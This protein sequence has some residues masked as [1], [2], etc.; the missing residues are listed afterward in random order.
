MDLEAGRKLAAGALVSCL[1]TNARDKRMVT[2][3]SR[4]DA[5]AGAVTKEW[6]GLTIGANL[7]RSIF[8]LSET[9]EVHKTVVSPNFKI[10]SHQVR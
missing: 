4:R 7:H 1:V 9:L 5:I 2:V 3:T 6:D 8:M 10:L